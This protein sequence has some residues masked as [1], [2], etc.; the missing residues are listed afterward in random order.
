MPVRSETYNLPCVSEQRTRTT[1][2]QSSIH[3]CFAHNGTKPIC[4]SNSKKNYPRKTKMKEKGF[5]KLRFHLPVKVAKAEAE[6]GS[7]FLSV[8]FFFFYLTGS[9]MALVPLVVSAASYDYLVA[10][11]WWWLLLQPLDVC[12]VGVAWYGVC[13]C[14][15]SN[16]M[17]SECIF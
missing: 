16:G 11:L 7:F 10:L 13:C 3:L 8:F 9:R 1:S 14:F 4:P 12:R 2:I 17:M 15:R 6:K 5:R